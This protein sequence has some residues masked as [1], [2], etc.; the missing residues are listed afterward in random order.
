MAGADTRTVVNQRRARIV[1]IWLLVLLG[2]AL[3]GEARAQACAPACCCP[4]VEH[5]GGDCAALAT[6]CCHADAE[7]RLPSGASGPVPGPA[8]AAP[9]DLAAPFTWQLAPACS[10]PPF[11]GDRRSAPL[12][13]SVVLRI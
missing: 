10:L 3:L 13:L 6:S 11:G 2:A 1:A 4:V 8:A 12:R 7:P 5:A 9:P